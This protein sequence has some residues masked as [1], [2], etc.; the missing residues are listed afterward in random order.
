MST[1]D[2]MVKTTVTISQNGV[3]D[4][5]QENLL[6]LNCLVRAKVQLKFFQNQFL[7][8]V[9]RAPEIE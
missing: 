5:S 9:K 4:F 7:A 3:L 6:A 2:A 1:E 8:L